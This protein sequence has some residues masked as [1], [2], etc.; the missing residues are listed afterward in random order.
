L[1]SLVPGVLCPRGESEVCFSVVQA[2]IVDMVYELAWAGVHNDTV[3]LYMPLPAVADCNGSCS[4]VA[5]WGPYQVP[6]V[7]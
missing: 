5:S 2:I 4:V 1:L 3:H 7:Y 6:F